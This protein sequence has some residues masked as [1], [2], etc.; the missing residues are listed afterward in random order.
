MTH[1][2]TQLRAVGLFYR[3]IAPF[4]LGI[5]ALLVLL[6]LLPLLHEGRAAGLLPR[7]AGAKLLT[8]PAV[9]YLAERARPQQ[10]WFYYNLGVSR[11]HLWTGVA[12]IDGLLFVGATTAT[13]ALVS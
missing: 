1:W 2:L 4:T 3:S 10:Y 11:R 7:L 9:W 12:V 13:T 8:G 6:V 5:T